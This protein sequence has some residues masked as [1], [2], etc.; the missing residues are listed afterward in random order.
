MREDGDAARRLA[1]AISGLGG[2]V[3]L[4]ERRLEV[5]DRWEQSIL[6]GIR[7]G[8]RLFVPMISARTEK[9][10]E[11]YVF[12]EWDEAVERARSIPLPT[13]HHS[14]GRRSRLRRQSGPVLQI[15]EAFRQYHFGRA[16]GGEPDVD[17]VTAL[18]TEI[19]AMRRPEA[20]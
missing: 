11:G 1:D 9:R 20:V 2:D 14:C 16:P 15:P 12:R 4:D 8:V 7:R 5:G 3:W 13:L 17:L 18:T 6:S 10:D 19:R